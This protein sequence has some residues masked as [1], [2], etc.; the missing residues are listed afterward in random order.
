M[1]Q[2][3]KGAAEAGKC[4]VDIALELMIGHQQLGV[5]ST[6][7]LVE[8]FTNNIA[9]NVE[10]NKTPQ[11][12][13]RLIETT[14]DNIDD[15]GRVDKFLDFLANMCSD[16]L[17][18][19]LEEEALYPESCKAVLK[20]VLDNPRV[21]MSRR[22]VH[23]DHGELDDVEI[24]ISTTSGDGNDEWIRLLTLSR[25]DEFEFAAHLVQKAQG[26]ALP[27]PVSSAPSSDSLQFSMNG[28]LTHFA[29]FAS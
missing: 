1:K 24:D 5:G 2:A 23:G 11:L 25:D 9:V 22:I 21:I 15:V 18:G 27:R 28:V 13:N 10:V 7:T 4:V 20:A 17:P 12:I 8:C 14:M 26:V 6:D 3:C 29:V 19:E 16:L